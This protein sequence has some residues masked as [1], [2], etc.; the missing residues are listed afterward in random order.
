MSLQ[1]QFTVKLQY[2]QPVIITIVLNPIMSHY[3]KYK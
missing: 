1:I 3:A 2:Y